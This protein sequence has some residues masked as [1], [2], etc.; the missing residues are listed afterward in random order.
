M[1]YQNSN[2]IVSREHNDSSFRP[3]INDIEGI[4]KTDTI[5]FGYPL[6]WGEAPQA[7]YTFIEKYKFNGKTSIPFC[8]SGSSKMSNSGKNLADK[9]SGAN[10]FKGQCFPSDADDDEVKKWTDKVVKINSNG[11]MKF[12]DKTLSDG[13]PIGA[14]IGIAVAA[15]VVVAIII[16]VVVIV[17]RKKRGNKSNAEVS[18]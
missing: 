15:V 12:N 10:W 1:N 6:W 8:T 7:V 9:T 17:V 11:E 4:D 3:E 2:S 16:V 18:N 13:L 5:F 14:I